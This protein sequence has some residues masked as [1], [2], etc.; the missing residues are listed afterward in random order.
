MID[1]AFTFDMTMSMT[2]C[3]FEVRNQLN[4]LLPQLFDGRLRDIRVALITHGDYDSSSYVT[5]HMN[6]TS[7]VGAMRDYVMHVSSA[8]SNIWN[9]GEAYEQALRVAK[10]E[11]SWRPGAKKALVVMGDDVPHPPTFPFNVDRVDWRQEL[12]QLRAMGVKTYGVQC[13]TLGR[14]FSAA[15]YDELSRETCG[16]ALPLHQFVHVADMMVILSYGVLES[17][18]ELEMLEQGMQAEGRY[19]RN[20]EILFNRLL[21]RTDRMS[22]VRSPT[23]STLSA[24]SATDLIPV[25]PSRFQVLT[26]VERRPIRSVVEEAGA[27]FKAGRG[28]YQLIKREDLS[29]KKQIVL[30]HNASGDMFT[31]EAAR[32]MM[33]LPIDTKTKV[34]PSNAPVGYTVF[35][36]S[37]SYNRM[38]DANTRFLYELEDDRA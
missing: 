21:H 24:L 12:A 32:A 28:F 13:P 37:T 27:V 23:I 31:G 36:Q 25:D 29:E 16:E 22:A 26:V 7:D 11:L 14:R 35:I 1:I 20:A 3:M 34:G 8:G 5:R 19:T 17:A 38:L 2:P 18:E 9:D 15:F 4:R 30:V 6:F 33:N 10:K